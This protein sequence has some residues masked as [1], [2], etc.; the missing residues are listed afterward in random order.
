MLAVACLARW[1]LLRVI[2][3]VLALWRAFAAYRIIQHQRSLDVV[4]EAAQR[5][6]E[7]TID[8]L[9]NQEATFLRS[10]L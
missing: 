8:R 7:A 10:M 9:L 4:A 1:P 3:G 2:T 6:G 5:T